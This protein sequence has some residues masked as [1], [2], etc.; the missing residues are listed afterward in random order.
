MSEISKWTLT[1]YFDVWGNEVDGWEVN[2]VSIWSDNIELEDDMTDKEIIN[3][4][5]EIGYLSPRARD[6]IKLIDGGDWIEIEF[7]DSDKPGI[8]M[9]RLNRNV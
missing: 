3:Q 7:S 5:I 2:D 4:L 6:Q 1:D 9:G 8:P